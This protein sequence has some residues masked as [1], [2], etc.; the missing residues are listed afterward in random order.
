MDSFLAPLEMDNLAG[1]L[2]RAL[3]Q[4]IYFGIETRI[5]YAITSWIRPLLFGKP[6]RPL[7]ASCQFFGEQTLKHGW[8]IAR[9]SLLF[10]STQRAWMAISG[11]HEPAQWQTFVSGCLAGYVFMVRDTKD[12]TLKKQINMAIGIR[13]L[14]AAACY[15]VRQKAVPM[16]ADTPAGY[17]RGTA[18]WYTLM[19]G[20]VM[21]HWRHQS[22]SK[23][24]NKAQVASMNFIYTGGDVPGKE[25]WFGNNYLVWLAALIAIRMV[26]KAKK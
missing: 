5:P 9:I 10:K 6:T 20:V 19:W 4:G 22:A 11:K 1:E 13:T 16:I 3:R 7:L 25:K 21:W 23:E 12:A 8:L 24:M 15:L 18:V 17:Q 26:P 14:Y 2:I